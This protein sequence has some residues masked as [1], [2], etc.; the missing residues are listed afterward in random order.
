MAVG[1]RIRADRAHSRCAK[2]LAGDACRSRG[3]V[4][5]DAGAVRVLQHHGKSLLAVGITAISGEFS[6]GSLLSC[7]D[8]EGLEVCRGLTN[9]SSEEL[10]RIQGK[11]TQ[12]IEVELG[13]LVDEEVIH[14]DDLL[15]V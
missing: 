10:K 9:Y 14:R 7:C 4:T 15:M 2:A 12:A 3:V 1:T 6:Q 13:Y 11:T 5:L 8:S